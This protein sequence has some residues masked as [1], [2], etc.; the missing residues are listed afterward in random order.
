M[1]SHSDLEA[2]I[3]R[4]RAPH[5]V[6]FYAGRLHRAGVSSDVLRGA[7][8]APPAD[9]SNLW[10]QLPSAVA[11][12][13]VAEELSSYFKHLSVVSAQLRYEAIRKESHIRPIA[14]I[15]RELLVSRQTVSKI[16]NTPTKDR[17]L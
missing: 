7:L 13:L 14:D 15:A 2:T 5:E 3:G 4:Y 17:M 1:S 16:A 12:A 10:G 8:A 11:V 6:A 9:L